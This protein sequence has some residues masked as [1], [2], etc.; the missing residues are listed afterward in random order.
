MK[1][2]ILFI[3]CIYS[4][5]NKDNYLNLSK[6]G[7]QFAAQSFQES[8]LDGFIANDVSPYVLTIP[9]LSSYPFGYKSVC[10]KSSIFVH[11]KTKLGKSIG[12]LNIPFV[13]S[14]A[15]YKLKKETIKWCDSTLGEKKIVVYGLHVNLMNA[16][17]LAKE[18]YPDVKLCIIIP[19][20]PQYMGCNKYYEVLGFKRREVKYIYSKIDKFDNYVV[21]TKPMIDALGIINKPHVIIEGIYSTTDAIIDTSIKSSYKIIFYSGGLRS[22]YG[23]RDLVDAFMKIKKEEYRLWLCGDGDA[24]EYIKRCSKVDSRI[25]YKGILPKSEVLRYQ[26]NVTLLVNPRHST[27]DFTKYSFPSKTL[28]YMASTTPILMCRLQCIPNEYQEYLYFFT[29]E[30]V[31]GMANDIQYICELNDNELKKKG[32]NAFRFVKENKNPKEQVKKIISLLN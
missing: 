15:K 28:E 12:Y 1:N 4:E 32:L 31:D 29:D 8:L 17:M 13:R 23:I 3:G 24:V 25:E 27:E 21:L 6:K 10:V 16:A 30:S 26:R 14:I 9:S 18:K 19:D 2:N 5:N 22:K 11:K 20:L 7:Y